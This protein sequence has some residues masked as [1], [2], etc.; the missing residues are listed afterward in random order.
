MPQAVVPFELNSKSFTIS[1][2][3]I[4]AVVRL[5]FIAQCALSRGP[6]YWVKATVW[7]MKRRV[8][9]VSYG[10]TAMRGQSGPHSP[11]S[12]AEGIGLEILAV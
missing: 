3:I 10:R 6:S 12:A 8:D 2:F 9:A 4:M 7:I 5:L 1:I 11:R